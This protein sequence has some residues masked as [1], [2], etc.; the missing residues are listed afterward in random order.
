[1]TDTGVNRAWVAALPD[2]RMKHSMHT[3]PE[4]NG[5]ASYGNDA[6]ATMKSVTSENKALIG[7]EVGL[8]YADRTEEGIHT[9]L[10]RV[11]STFYSS[12]ILPPQIELIWHLIC[13]RR[14]S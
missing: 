2:E 4:K 6:E 11:S 10:R 1:M 12:A 14:Q 9:Q 3:T 8:V 5:F 7:V 13:S